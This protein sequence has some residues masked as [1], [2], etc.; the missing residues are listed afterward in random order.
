MLENDA[1]GESGTQ[2]DRDVP[3]LPRDGL[4]SL[5]LCPHGVGA[6]AR[7]AVPPRVRLQSALSNPSQLVG[8]LVAWGHERLPAGLH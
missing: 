5:E 3:A 2:G 6:K 1:D 8:M 4:A 7:R